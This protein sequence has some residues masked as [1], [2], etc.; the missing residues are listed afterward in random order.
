[1]ANKSRE[2][3]YWL[4][5]QSNITYKNKKKLLPL[6]KNSENCT[7]IRE[8]IGNAIEREPYFLYDVELEKVYHSLD[9]WDFSKEYERFYQMGGSFVLY[10][11]ASFPKRLKDYDYHPFALFYLGELPKDD[12]L[13]VGI[14]GARKCSYYGEREAV[15]YGKTLAEAGVQIISGMAAGIDG[16]AQRSALSVGGKSFAVVGTGIDICYP[17]CNKGL[18][19]DLI[20]NGG[21]ISEFPIGIEAL[22]HHFPMRN[23]NI[24]ALSDVLLIIEAKTKSGSLI[25]ADFAMEQGKDV[26]ALPGTTTSELSKGCNQLIKQGAGIL[27]SPEDFLQDLQLF[28]AQNNKNIIKNENLLVNTE[29]LVYS[30]LDLV[31]LNLSEILNQTKLP[32]SEVQTALVALELKEIVREVAKN[33]YI[34]L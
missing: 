34:R 7:E 4:A 16:I 3:I 11:E 9:T 21:V 2:I 1:M 27:L 24:S 30:C 15:R 8:Q 22:P 28:R 20:K 13:T 6:I 5:S 25:T 17:K 14:V 26:Y 33:Y 10:N 31:P 12:V 32:L 29:K 19:E 23:R 18:Y